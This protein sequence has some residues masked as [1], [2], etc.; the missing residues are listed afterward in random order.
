MKN[1]VPE[2]FRK[3]MV[4][5]YSSSLIRKE[6]VEYITGFPFDY[7]D[8]FIHTNND[9]KYIN[10]NSIPIMVDGNI[11]DDRIQFDT[12]EFYVSFN[13]IMYLL[14]EMYKKGCIENYL[15]SIKAFFDIY[16]DYGLLFEAWRTTKNEE[17]ALGLY[18]TRVLEKSIVRSSY[19]K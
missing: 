9:I 18:K 4:K 17:E 6:A 11:I 12:K 8:K 2:Q 19:K 10:M 16:L 7:K 14:E 15:K 3:I 1:N 13:N 5:I